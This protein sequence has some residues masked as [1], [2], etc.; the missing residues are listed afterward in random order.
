MYEKGKRRNK[1]SFGLT[2]PESWLW[3]MAKV[4]RKGRPADVTVPL[5]IT[6]QWLAAV[7]DQGSKMCVCGGVFPHD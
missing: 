3:L 2:D 6:E 1:K 5:L 4:V 7:K